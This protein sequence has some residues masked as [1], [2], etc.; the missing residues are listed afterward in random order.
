MDS[1]NPSWVCSIKKG[2]RPSCWIWMDYL[3]LRNIRS[4]VCF[5]SFSLSFPVGHLCAHL[6]LRFRLTQPAVSYS[7][8]TGSNKL[9]LQPLEQNSSQLCTSSTPFVS[10]PPPEHSLFV[11]KLCSVLGVVTGYNEA[12]KVGRTVGRVSQ[13]H[14]RRSDS[15]WQ[16]FGRRRGLAHENAKDLCVS[17]RH[18]RVQLTSSMTKHAGS[19]TGPPMTNQSMGELPYLADWRH[20]A[21]AA[22]SGRAFLH[23]WS[24]WFSNTNEVVGWVTLQSMPLCAWVSADVWNTLREALF[25]DRSHTCVTVWHVHRRP[26]A[27]VG[28]SSLHVQSHAVLL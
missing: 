22:T 23:A 13:Q 28:I 19:E 18:P 8:P 9:R 7:D 21:E 5:L 11:I 3:E 16:R 10:V 20:E 14:A 17:V 2:K 26:H 1:Q 15:G 25:Y 4:P 12:N 6:S 24:V 27:A